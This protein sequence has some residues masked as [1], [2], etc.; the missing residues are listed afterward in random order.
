MSWLFFVDEFSRSPGRKPSFP[1]GTGLW[2]V[3]SYLTAYWAFLNSRVSSNRL[4]LDIRLMEMSSTQ[5]AKTEQFESPLAV[6]IQY[7][8]VVG[9]MQVIGNDVEMPTITLPGNI[10]RNLV[11]NELI[12]SL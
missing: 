2:P 12:D 8:Q 9:L 6:V 5:L 4:P 1:V 10:K 7:P 11:G 3:S